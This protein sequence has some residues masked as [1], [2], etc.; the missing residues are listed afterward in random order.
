M[1]ALVEIVLM[2]SKGAV[3]VSIF[4]R[5]LNTMKDPTMH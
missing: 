1:N 3:C 5:S 2:L 4:K